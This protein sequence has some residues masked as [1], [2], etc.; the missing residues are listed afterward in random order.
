[1]T[2][3]PDSRRETPAAVFAVALGLFL[4]A[5]S[6]VAMFLVRLPEV[7]GAALLDERF[8]AHDLP[9]GME[10][11]DAIQL[12]RGEEVV[13]LSDPAI[14]SE[15]RASER[16]VWDPITKKQEAERGKSFGGGSER[17]GRGSS[18]RGGGG[19]G[20][21]HGGPGTGADFKMMDWSSVEAGEAGQDPWEVA[22]VWY[23]RKLAEKVL[24]TQFGSRGFDDLRF[25]GT[26]GGKA[27]VALGSV[28]WAGY[29][30]HY[31]IER[32]FAMVDDEK[33]FR[34]TL[35]VNLSLGTRGC[36]LYARWAAGVPGSID[37]VSTLLEGFTPVAPG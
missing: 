29:D 13:V 14:W 5:V 20:G 11:V 22:F 31:V 6:A 34:D 36:V 21:G 33:A 4:I 15:G 2:T 16:L 37:T 12:V 28:A 35:R 23:P 7:D 24:N 3:Q 25:I 30:T 9:V 27:T 1:M 17:G 18:R 8:A 19:H 10:V 32:Q 26:G